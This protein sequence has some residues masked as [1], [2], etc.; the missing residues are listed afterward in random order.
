MTE[1]VYLE[2]R[3][4]N[5]G[6]LVPGGIQSFNQKLDYLARLLCQGRNGSSQCY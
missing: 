2:M 4:G 1:I 5:H 3:E 6:E